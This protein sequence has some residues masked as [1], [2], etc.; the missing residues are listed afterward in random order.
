MTISIS[1]PA[2][3]E[4][5]AEM[6]TVEPSRHPDPQ[7]VQDF[8]GN[9]PS[10]L[11]KGFWRTIQLR[12]GLEVVLGNLQQHDRFLTA[13]PEGEVDWLELHLH[14]T[15]FHELGGNLI[16]AGQYGLSGSGL[17]P[18]MALKSSDQ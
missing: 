8:M 11:G 1:Q 10:V 17:L 5:F 6:S 9:F 16:G 4:L 14:L 15:G 18:R 3:D 2:Y 12:D 13:H 7:D